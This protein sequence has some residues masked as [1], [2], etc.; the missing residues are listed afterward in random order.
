MSLLGKIF[1]FFPLSFYGLLAVSLVSFAANPGLINFI[2][3]LYVLYFYPLTVFRLTNIFYP[4]RPGKYD[5]QTSDFN[6]WWGSHQV[7]LV[8]YAMPFLEASLRIIPGA[9]SFWLRLW[10]SKIGKK[11]YWT[12]NIEIDDRT[13]LEIGD[14]T[15][16]GHKFSFHPHV[17]GP[18]DGKLM[19]LVKKI[20][21]GKKCFL[22]AGSDLAPGV[23]IDD[24]VSIPILTKG[25]IDRHFKKGDYIND[26]KIHKEMMKDM[27]RKAG[28]EVNEDE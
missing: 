20:K 10:G 25:R 11:I 28:F 6:P 26:H 15:V 4:L 16:I 22:G 9:Y 12:P 1:V 2:F 3:I 21:I 8:Y 7:Q 5:L 13:M 18:K 14:H 27:D 24:G 19:L 23:I 17:I